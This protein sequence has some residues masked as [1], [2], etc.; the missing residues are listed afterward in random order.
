[1]WIKAEKSTN[2]S[3]GFSCWEKDFVIVSAF[4]SGECELVTLLNEGM[5]ILGIIFYIISLKLNVKEMFLLFCIWSQKINK[6]TSAVIEWPMLNCRL[7]VTKLFCCNHLDVTLMERW[8]DAETRNIFAFNKKHICSYGYHSCR[9]KI[10]LLTS[11]AGRNLRFLSIQV[12]EDDAV[13][14]CICSL[15]TFS[16]R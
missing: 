8:T 13:W 6:A 4:K 14:I 5:H 2:A 1:M 9:L 12:S 15:F 7:I 11:P 10:V 3:S 16:E